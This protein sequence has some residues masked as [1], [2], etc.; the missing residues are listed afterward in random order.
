MEGEV[1]RY[2]RARSYTP[3]AADLKTL[4]GRYEATSFRP[5][6]RD[7]FQ[8]RLMTVRVHRDKAG[9]VVAFDYKHSGGPQHQVHTAE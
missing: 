2:R 1:T 3:T 5:V 9:K 6:D 4:A 7:I 8:F